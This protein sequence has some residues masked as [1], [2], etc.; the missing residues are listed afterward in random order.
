MR[1]PPWALH[2]TGVTA[3]AVLMGAMT[4]EAV[5]LGIPT[6]DGVS[7]SQT[8]SRG[9]TKSKS[10]DFHEASRL[11]L[12]GLP[13][14][15]EP[16]FDELALPEE[17][18][19]E[20]EPEDEELLPTDLPLALVGTSVF[21]DPTRLS[22]A[23]IRDLDEKGSDA[24]IYASRPCPG[25]PC[26]ELPHEATLLSIDVEQ[27]II[28]NADTGKKE[29]LVLGAKKKKGKRKK[30][31][32]KPY[33]GKTPEKDKKPNKKKAK[34]SDYIVEKLGEGRY[35]IPPSQVAKAMGEMAQ[36]SRMARA[37]PSKDGFQLKWI[38]KGSVFEMLGLK[39]GDVIQEVNG[40]DVRT[41]D[42]AMSAFQRLQ[43][44]TDFAVDI[45]RGSGKVTHEYTISD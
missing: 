25:Q 30:K 20:V 39:K 19:P 34:K 42:G 24:E 18:E 44:G 35:K 33:A 45:K 27:A 28:L 8:S 21:V 9:R 6:G 37:V 2:L 29:L 17:E 31:K 16:I 41:M 43:A 14:E 22:L 38:R 36:L 23:S 11:N 10:R 7:A 1:L 32:P 3:A 5:V 40:Y 26:A 12:F 4:G 13:F 15:E